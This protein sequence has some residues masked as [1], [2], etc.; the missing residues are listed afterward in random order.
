MQVKVF[1]ISVY[2]NGELQE[3]MNSFLRTHKVLTVDKQFVSQ[4]LDYVW[5]FCVTYIEG[6]KPDES[7][8]SEKRDYQKELE[9]AAAAVYS[10]LR[11]IRKEMSI[12]AAVAPFII[13]SNYELSEFAKLAVSDEGLSVKSMLQVKGVG[14]QKV[15]NYGKRFLEIYNSQMNTSEESSTEIAENKQLNLL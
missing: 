5:T 14:K 9:P 11:D 4:G 12:A 7:K 2:D 8:E 6:G 10:Q 1:H 13:F 3:E 15:N